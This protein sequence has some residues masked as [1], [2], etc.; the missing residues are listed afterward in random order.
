MSKTDKIHIDVSL[1]R[2][3][4]ATQFPQWADLPIKPV[5]FSGWD[6]RTFH[7]G[8]HMTARLPSNEEYASQVENEQHWL[9][10]LAPFLPRQIP[11]PLARGKPAE[12]YPLPV[13]WRLPGHFLKVKVGRHS[14]QRCLLIMAHGRVVGVGHYGRH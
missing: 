1:V 7:L 9:P 13:I 5:E 12:G 14:V 4:I 3:L 6:N 11:V 2:R 8:G 10:K